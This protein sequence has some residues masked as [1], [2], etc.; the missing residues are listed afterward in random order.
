MDPN[1]ASEDFSNLARAVNKPYLIWIFGVVDPEEWDK[2]AAEGTLSQ[3]PYP[4]SPFFAPKIQPTMSTGV[5]AMSLA[6]LTFLG[7]R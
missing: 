4:H 6:A 2:A 1:P 3:F 7:D 5:D